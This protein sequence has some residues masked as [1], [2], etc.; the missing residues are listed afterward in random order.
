MSQACCRQCIHREIAETFVSVAHC[1]CNGSGST[2]VVDSISTWVPCVMT[3]LGSVS[4]AVG[5]LERK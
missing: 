5:K 2:E 3:T 1:L 4:V